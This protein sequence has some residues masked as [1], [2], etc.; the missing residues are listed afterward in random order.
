M[1][2]KV[3][4]IVLNILVWFN[5]ICFV[6]LASTSLLFLILM[7]KG[8]GKYAS[9]QEYIALQENSSVDDRTDIIT[10]MPLI[11]TPFLVFSA[12]LERRKP[13]IRFIFIIC[14]IVIL[15]IWYIAYY[16]IPYNG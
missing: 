12:L 2:D 14:T 16:H 11:I 5:R 13:K 3:H 1:F 9:S 8:F 6:L 10:A 7:P 15:G 4:K